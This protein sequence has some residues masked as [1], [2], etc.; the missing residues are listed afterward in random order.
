MTSGAMQVRRLNPEE[1]ARFAP[2]IPGLIRETS[3]ISYDY[4]FGTDGLLENLVSLSWSTADT[5]F[6]AACATAAVADG[7][8]L[9]VELGFEGSNFRTFQANLAPLAL[10]LVAREAVT[11][12]Q[13]VALAERAAKVSYLNAYIPD[14][15]YYLHALSAFP[16]YRGR[17]VGKALLAAAI[18]RA[19]AAGYREL[20]L[21][22]LADNP[23]VG[24]YQANGLSIM[25]ETRSVELSRDHGF[26]AEYRMAM[27]L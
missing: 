19:R 24:F 9:G 21:D 11:Y 26:P 15:V 5:L 2:F 22:V 27:T 1:M 6:S 10:D 25:V 13:L 16:Q 14:Q 17:G 18:A 20:Q 12:D 23:A 4:S 3:P 8:L 7:D